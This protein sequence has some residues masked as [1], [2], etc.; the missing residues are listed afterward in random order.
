MSGRSIDVADS[1]GEIFRMTLA[2]SEWDFGR[3][4]THRLGFGVTGCPGVEEAEE[5]DRGVSHA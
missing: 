4:L 2:L 1:K 5:N 3:A